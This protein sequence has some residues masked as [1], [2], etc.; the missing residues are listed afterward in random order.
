MAS[1]E[2]KQ[3]IEPPRFHIGQV[4]SS[5]NLLRRTG[6]RYS[7]LPWRK[8]DGPD[9]AFE[10]LVNCVW[11]ELD[12]ANPNPKL[13]RIFD[14][15]LRMV[16]QLA[17][18]VPLP[19]VDGHLFDMPVS[20]WAKTFE[21]SNKRKGSAKAVEGTPKTSIR[22]ALA[23][24]DPKGAV[25][26]F[27]VFIDD[28]KLARP[29]KFRNLPMSSHALKHP[30]VFIG[31]CDERFAKI[32][33]ELS[34]GRLQFEAYLFW[35]PKIAPTEHQGSLIRIHGSS[36]TLFDPT[37]MRYQISEQTRL[38]QITCEIFVSDGLDSALNI[39]RESFNNAHPHAVYITRWLHGA[40]RQLATA[41][42]KA[43]GE[44][45]VQ[46]RE[47]AK[48]ARVDSIQKIAAQVWA[49]QANDAASLPPSI[50]IVEDEKAA[51]KASDT[52]VYRRSSVT[53]RRK[54]PTTTKERTRVVILEEK[55]K[56]IAQVLASFGLIDRLTRKQQESLLL[57]V[58]RILEEREE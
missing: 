51:K 55:L 31:K 39:D 15:Y 18:A 48:D 3:A 28:L 36:G 38:R 7:S 27:D 6:D 32:S 23:L 56:A 33:P 17:L 58:Y 5:G 50:E 45:R 9:K 22:N 30:I 14:Y 16:W 20:G 42:K 19:Y 21:I 43:A 34:G 35:S 10:K 26:T 57:A 25:G 29:I 52:Y 1:E 44:V 53:D 4:D 2:E 11:A 13:E 41:Q 12:Q 47:V 40:L 37:F 46:T 49:D 24:T 54:Q 8:S